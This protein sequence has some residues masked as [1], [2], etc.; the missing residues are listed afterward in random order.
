MPGFGL[1]AN[2]GEQ[3]AYSIENVGNAAAKL[4][5]TIYD[6]L[7]ES[8]IA[9]ETQ[10]GQI[11]LSQSMNQFDAQLAQDPDTDVDSVQGKWTKHSSDA[12]KLATDSMKNP[13]AKK[14]I[15][16]WWNSTSIAH[17]ERINGQII[18]KRRDYALDT[19]KNNMDKLE[20]GGENN[21]TLISQ[22]LHA[23]ASASLIT[24]AGAEIEEAQRFKRIDTNTF[25]ANGSHEMDK[26]EISGFQWMLD[27]ANSPWAKQSERE[28]LAKSTLQAHKDITSIEDKKIVDANIKRSGELHDAIFGALL[29]K[30]EMP[31]FDE[32]M[33]GWKSNQNIDGSQQRESIQ[34]Y[35]HSSL[36]SINR[37]NNPVAGFVNVFNDSDRTKEDY[38]SVLQAYRSS[39]AYSATG[40]MKLAAK[41]KINS[42]DKNANVELIVK[43]FN[44]EPTQANRSQILD[45]F[46]GP[47]SQYFML[48]NQLK[49]PK[50]EKDTAADIAAKDA[51]NA[52]TEKWDHSMATKNM[53]ATREEAIK[54]VD[55]E[56]WVDTPTVFRKEYYNETMTSIDRYYR[57]LERDA[58]AKAKKLHGGKLTA[59]Q[60]D[61]FLSSWYAELAEGKL[62]LKTQDIQET[63]VKLDKNLS[64]ENDAKQRFH[65]KMMEAQTA[66]RTNMMPAFEAMKPDP[67]ASEDEKKVYQAVFLHGLD[68]A[69]GHPDVTDP[70]MLEKK[71]QEFQQTY[72]KAY[73]VDSIAKGPKGIPGLFVP[74]N[75][76]ELAIAEL[77]QTGAI[78]TAAESSK[79]IKAQYEAFENKISSEAEAKYP[80]ITEYD[81]APRKKG[82]FAKLQ[83]VYRGLSKDKAT[84]HE[85]WKNGNKL[86][87]Y[88]LPM[89]KANNFTDDDWIPE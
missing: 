89:S 30:N 20:Q 28:S 75:A 70:E 41:M 50:N 54:Q 79:D 10:K 1:F 60:E 76:D 74:K 21:K 53:P 87:W 35:Y 31:S 73:I 82:K 40:E 57:G 2:A 45:G 48:V 42:D 80:G 83:P 81:V 67:T 8:E 64:F 39:D 24:P 25:M 38:D 19:L 61:D 78:Q 43:E 46:T 13:G 18:E 3:L 29:G 5:F 12:L 34:D 27:P 16:N 85:L 84:I 71:L 44:K 9:V 62:P 6:K 49:V 23:A 55:A 72:S 65:T 33:K 66:I 51:N 69:E 86:T 37:E 17:S 11:M 56:T 15:E 36:E 47:S 26:D 7:N 68:W 32:M 52:I 88:S 14:A 59:Q 58:L 22:G 77:A 63:M 4:G